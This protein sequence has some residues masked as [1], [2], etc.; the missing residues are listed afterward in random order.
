MV[1]ADEM[2]AESPLRGAPDVVSDWEATR[3]R[4]IWQMPDDVASSAYSSL[5]SKVWSNIKDDRLV[6]VILPVD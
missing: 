4:P 3:D 5:E 6:S 2:Q 1:R